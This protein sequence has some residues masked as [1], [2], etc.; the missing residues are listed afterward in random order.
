MD[1]PARPRGPRLR[2]PPP[3]KSIPAA[4]RVKKARSGL[5]STKPSIAHFDRLK[6]AIVPAAGLLSGWIA[7]AETGS[8]FAQA[9]SA[10]GGAITVGLLFYFLR[11]RGLAYRTF[12]SDL[13]GTV[14]ALPDASAKFQAIFGLKLGADSLGRLKKVT[15]TL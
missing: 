5:D 2:E 15:S 8:A 1:G 14:A 9:I 4:H 6:I 13:P 12:W 3:E 10:A 7:Q 11:Q